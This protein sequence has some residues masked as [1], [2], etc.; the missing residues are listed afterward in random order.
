MGQPRDR[1]RLAAA[2][3]VLHQVALTGPV[4][5][6]VGDQL[7]HG[8][9]LVVAGKDQ[10]LAARL[11]PVLIE[12]VEHLDKALYQVEH[13][14]P[15]PDLFP[16]IG[17]GEPA[18]RRAGGRISCAVVVALVKGQEVRVPIPQ[19]GGDVDELI[20]D[21]QVGQAASQLEERLARWAVVPVLLDRVRDVLAGE[22]VFEFDGKE[23]Q[24]VEKEDQVELWLGRL[25][26]RPIAELADDTE[27]V[28]LVAV[29]LVGVERGVRA[30]VGQPKVTAR[31]LELLPQGAESP[32]PLDQPCQALGEAP[33]GID[34]I[35]R[36]V[37]RPLSGLSGLDKLDRQLGV[38][39]ERPV[40]VGGRT[41]E[42]A[43]ALDQDAID[44][45]L[46]VGLGDVDGHRSLLIVALDG[47]CAVPPQI[48]AYRRW[49]FSSCTSRCT[50][51]H[52]LSSSVLCS[53]P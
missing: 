11:D 19:V 8:D 51:V 50:V 31:V 39:A 45:G 9:E 21:G 30:K 12:R 42:V 26:L 14:V 49:R 29:L 38:Q 47:L 6:R 17:G 7:A 10:A 32:S 46:K 53:S 2:C 34:G 20:V 52:G 1:H 23:G 16:Q 15:R 18:R 40:I 28:A 36:S 48:A 24:A 5:A 13:A 33:C 25:P 3:A 27:Q 43:V 4:S 44:G 22:L 35:L 37:S 41:R